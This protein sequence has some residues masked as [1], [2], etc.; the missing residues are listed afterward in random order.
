MKTRLVTLSAHQSDLQQHHRS[1]VV[2]NVPG[3]MK[4]GVVR[5][6]PLLRVIT[7]VAAPLHRTS[8]STPSSPTHP[9]GAP[10]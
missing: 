1:P 8:S 9:T 7:E 3:Q 4:S 10:R 5:S 6:K 2:R